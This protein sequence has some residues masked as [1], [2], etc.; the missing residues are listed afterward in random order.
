MI[1]YYNVHLDWFHRW[2]GG[3]PAPHDVSEHARQRGIPK[4]AEQ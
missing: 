3:E 2:L 1:F 4:A